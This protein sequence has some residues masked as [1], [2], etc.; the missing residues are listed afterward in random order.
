[1]DSETTGPRELDRA[2]FALDG[3][4][5]PRFLV[6]V[7]AR[8]YAYPVFPDSVWLCHPGGETLEEARAASM[9]ANAG[10]WVIIVERIDVMGEDWPASDRPC[11]PDYLLRE[12]TWLVLVP[13]PRLVPSWI[14]PRAC[15]V[16]RVAHAGEDEGLACGA[17]AAEPA[18]ALLGRVC[19]LESVE[20]GAV[21]RW[22]RK[23]ATSIWGGWR[24]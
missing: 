10:E 9:Q 18:R 20:A 1:V 21:V 14:S 15:L 17:L 6:C 7:P 22:L 3:G 19:T 13:S 12:G 4:A 5:A 8:T 2:L 23:D 16:A 24:D 11:V